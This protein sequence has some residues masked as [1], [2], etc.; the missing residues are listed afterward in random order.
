MVDIGQPCSIPLC[1][2]HVFEIHTLLFSRKIGLLFN[3]FIH[4]QKLGP[5]LNFSNVFNNEFH[6]TEL[7]AFSNS[8]NS[9]RSLCCMFHND[10]KYL[11]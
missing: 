5:K 10:K 1:I 8:K 2:S 11:K 7:R 4:F 3:N 9:K 6:S